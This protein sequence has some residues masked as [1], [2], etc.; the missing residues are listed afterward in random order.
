MV[1]GCRI[2]RDINH[3]GREPQRMRV[4]FLVT[5]TRDCEKIWR[6]LEFLGQ[7]E[8]VVEK[9][10]D[11]PHERHRELVTKAKGLRPDAIIMM[12]AIELYHRKP[13]P[14]IDILAELNK[15]APLIHIVSDAGDR[16]WWPFLEQYDQAGCF[17][18]QV[19]I[20]GVNISPITKCKNGIVLLTPVDPRPYR[21]RIWSDRRVTCGMAGNRSFA[22]RAQAIEM[23]LTTGNFSFFD[24]AH[25]R[26]YREMAAFL[27]R[28]RLVFNHPMTGSGHGEHVKGRVL[29]AAWAK[30]CLLEKIGSPITSWFPKNHYK[31]YKD[32]LEAVDIISWFNSHPEAGEDIALRLHSAVNDNH[33]PQQFWG[34]VFTVAGL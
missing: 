31:S 15:I 12:G 8:I 2:R 7:H 21:P 30:S 20:D 34:R 29:E 32:P 26:S 33:S 18:V 25:K 10:D 4:Y 1:D 23:L 16:F 13:V 14:K 11:R 24:A 6:S 28:C 3:R 5:S 27:S 22:A 19:G 9:Y 17:S